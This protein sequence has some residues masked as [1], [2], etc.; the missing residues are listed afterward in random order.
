M[1]NYLTREQFDQWI[2][3]LESGEYQKCC[4]QLVTVSEQSGDAYCCLGVA[5]KV[6]DIHTSSFSY[7]KNGHIWSFLDSGMQRVIAK[8]NDESDTFE[9]VVEQ[10]KKWAEK[11]RIPFGEPIHD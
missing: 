10:L 11:G 8:L 5:Q 9:P 4:R 6:F 1:N 7:L 3:A 2:E